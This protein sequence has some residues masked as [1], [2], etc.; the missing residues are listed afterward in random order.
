[1]IGKSTY[2]QTGAEVEVALPDGRI[3]NLHTLS[4]IG[5]LYTNIAQTTPKTLGLTLRSPPGMPS[6]QIS[7]QSSPLILPKQ[8][9]VYYYDK[10]HE[11]EAKTALMDTETTACHSFNG[12]GKST[13]IQT[14]INIC[15]DELDAEI[16]VDGQ[17]WVLKSVLDNGQLSFAM[18]KREAVKPGKCGNAKTASY[19][20]ELGRMRR[21]IDLKMQ[22]RMH[23]PSRSNETTRYI[24]LYVVV[25]NALFLRSGSDLAKTTTRALKIINYASKLYSQ[26]N[27]YL[28]VV[29]LEIWSDA[30]KIVVT[31]QVSDVLSRFVNYRRFVIN[32]VTNND[33]A[34]LFVEDNFADGTVGQGA[35]SV[36]SHV[37]SAA[38]VADHYPDDWIQAA[39]TMAHELGH[40]LGLKHDDEIDPSCMCPRTDVDDDKCIMYSM[41][42]GK[43]LKFNNSLLF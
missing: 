9:K 36:C 43:L 26:M 10:E 27:I 18:K 19:N 17:V 42:D 2:S 4:S 25:D 12:D 8:L 14:Q 41:S 39:T 34:Q 30:D 1:M 35:L 16:R 15:N 38:V 7:L 32:K 22:K 20:S 37:G 24:E 40:N 3:F 29:G 13:S 33:N 31:G 28:A 5:A 21:D 6:V 11:G 23:A